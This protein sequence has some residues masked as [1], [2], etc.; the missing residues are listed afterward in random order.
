MQL[1][2]MHA[3]V[4]VDLSEVKQHNEGHE[5]NIGEVRSVADPEVSDNL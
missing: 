2:R 3:R 4:G 5:V 1:S